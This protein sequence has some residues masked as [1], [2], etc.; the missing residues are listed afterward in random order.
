MTHTAGLRDTILTMHETTILCFGDSNTFGQRPDTNARYDESVRWPRR[1]GALLA[2][3][4]RQYYVI[5]EGLGGRRTDLD[6]PNPAKPSRNGWTYFPPCLASHQ[7]DIAI[8]MLGTNDAQLYH[9]RP[10]EAIVTALARY[11][12]YCH[13]SDVTPLL[14]APLIPDPTGLFNEAI[15][16]RSAWHFDDT[17]VATLTALPEKIRTYAAKHG[18]AFFDA[19]TYAKAGVDG[20]HWT[21]A[22]HERFARAIAQM[23]REIL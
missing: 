8:I 12:T 10:V 7:P 21:A 6:H 5:E 15:V 19:N 18:V 2:D 4:T 3:E 9:Q 1:L 17:A 16:P 20:L 23:I 13:E 22:G 14:V 11:V